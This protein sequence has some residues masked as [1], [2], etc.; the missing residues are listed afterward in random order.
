[1]EGVC[2]PGET[3]EVPL[4]GGV[5]TV[6]IP[7]LECRHDDRADKHDERV[8]WTIVGGAGALAAAFAAYMRRRQRARPQV[9]VE[10]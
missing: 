3:R 1:M 5:G 8:G 7:M 9:S 2:V 10:P 4:A 6:T